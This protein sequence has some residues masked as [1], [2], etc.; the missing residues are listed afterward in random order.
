MAKSYADCANVVDVFAVEN[1]DCAS[2][3]AVL[4]CWNDELAIAVVV[5]I[6]SAVKVAPPRYIVFPL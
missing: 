4:A 5:V 3:V 2:D 6:K 1:A